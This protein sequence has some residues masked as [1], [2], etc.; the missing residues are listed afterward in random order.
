LI[1]I[2]FIGYRG[3]AQKDTVVVYSEVVR[4]DSASKETLYIRARDWFN[5]AFKDSKEVLQI[6]D[7]D[8]GEISGKGSYK[9]YISHKS[10][11][12][13]N[14]YWLNYRFK[15]TVWTKGGRYKYEITDIDNYAASADGVM[16]FGILTSS[17]HTEV[18]YAMTS[19]KKM[20][21][22]FAMANNLS[23][24]KINEIVA[25][26]KSSMAKNATPDF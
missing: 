12:I 14:G 19:K 8:A 4:V 18:Q 22:Y 15:V 25:S 3:V 20:D 5:S 23:K 1:L 7:K 10:L 21:G 24:N 9:I 11:G 6:Q 17:I 26:L 13:E 16:P 2:T